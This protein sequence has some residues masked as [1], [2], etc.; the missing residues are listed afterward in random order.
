MLNSKG[1]V[2]VMEKSNEQ[3]SDE[4][5]LAAEI[6]ENLDK[7]VALVERANKLGLAVNFSIRPK[8]LESGEIAGFEGQCRIERVT[9]EEF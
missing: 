7:S 4:E 1:N 6:R 8:V 2:I 5:L 3:K 9:T